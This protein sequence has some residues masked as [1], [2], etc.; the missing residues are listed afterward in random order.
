MAEPVVVARISTDDF[1]GLD[2]LDRAIQ[3]FQPGDLG[4]IDLP[5]DSEIAVGEE[6]QSFQRDTRELNGELLRS[7]LQP[8][9]GRADIA[10]L[11]WAN[12]SVR[13][14][15]QVKGQAA[16]GAATSQFGDDY[17]FRHA[18]PYAVFLAGIFANVVRMTATRIGGQAAMRTMVTKTG[19]TLRPVG[20]SFGS[21]R[22]AIQTSRAAYKQGLRRGRLVFAMP[23]LR[24]LVGA[25]ALIFFALAPGK[26]IELLKWGGEKTYQYVIKPIGRAA[27][28]ALGDFGK[29]LKKGVGRVGLLAVGGVLVVGGLYLF[30]RRK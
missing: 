29:A 6:L 18:T 8:W 7:G 5:L 21:Q 9:P 20:A 12:R 13:L 15:F 30:M 24:V 27:A 16:L 22:A 14:L 1:S 25:G 23:S 4:R 17:P 28:G 11:D 19:R 26:F 3:A 10:E 2:Q